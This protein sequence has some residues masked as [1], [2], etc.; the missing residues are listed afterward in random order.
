ML[1]IKITG[2]IKIATTY[3]IPT[4]PCCSYQVGLHQSW[5]RFSK[6]WPLAAGTLA[7]VQAKMVPKMVPIIKISKSNKSNDP[8]LPVT[9]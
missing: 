7:M 9:K 6:N 2:V 1:S 5:N 4:G 8:E 3:C